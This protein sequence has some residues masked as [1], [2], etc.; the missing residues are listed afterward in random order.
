M[1]TTIDLRSDTVTK[2]TRK[3]REAMFN[4]EVGDDCYGEDVT[5]QRLEALAAEKVGKG[6]AM[7]VPTGTMGNTAAILA[8]THAGDY[9]IVDSEC[10]IYYYE[11]G[12]LASLA[13]IMPIVMDSADG[14]PEPDAVEPYL[15]RDAAKFPKTSLICLE[16]THNRR[17]GQ[18]VAL[19]RMRAIH[20]LAQRY[21]VPVH[22][23]GAR[24]FNAAHALGVDAREITSHVDSV[25]FCLSKGLCAPVG[26]MLAG[27]ADFIQQA[28]GARKR[29][30]G[31]MRQ[32]GVLAAAG[33]VALTE[34]TDRLGEDHTNAKL[35]AKA[36]SQF[37][38]L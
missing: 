28:R 27:D 26:S 23:D 6:A 29:L 7:Y 1:D 13:G 11:H 32:S 21:D 3:M 12:N 8:H 19:D 33:I 35:L 14:V 22:L 15:Q 2:P 18:A 9:A 24:I 10:H 30:G 16:N 31:A 37:D 4:A 34:M 36:L 25:M 20:D 17:G 38:E 5:V